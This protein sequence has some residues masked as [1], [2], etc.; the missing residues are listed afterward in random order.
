MVVSEW[1]EFDVGGGGCGVVGRGADRVI[2]AEVLGVEGFGAEVLG[3]EEFRAEVLALG[4]F[5]A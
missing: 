4:G 2:T 3:V 5:R 1:S